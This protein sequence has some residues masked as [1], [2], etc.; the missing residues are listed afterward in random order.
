MV[1]LGGIDI[2]RSIRQ[3]SRMT[4]P[5]V[6]ASSS[7]RR[8]EL[9]AQLGIDFDIVPSDVPEE[10]RPHESAA[11]F[12]GRVAQEKA[13][14]VAAQRPAQ[15]ILAADTVVAI[16]DEILGKPADRA[17][18]YR[19]LR[20]L[21]DR[22]HQVVTAVVLLAPGGRVAEQQVFESAVT[23]RIIREDEIDRYVD[24]GEPFDKAGGY[25]IQGRASPFV[26]KVEGSY[27]NVVGLPLDEV[28][29]ML[30]RH[31]LLET[32]SATPV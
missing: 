9:L 7:P 32:G 1:V 6:L 13:V 14:H 20:G 31:E 4:A 21:S 8:R 19:M 22:T 27:S 10:R 29:E 24:T 18:A 28:R 11:V 5:L 23:M 16:D 30:A 3:Q 12:A 15:W 25:G 2:V 17:D 26:S